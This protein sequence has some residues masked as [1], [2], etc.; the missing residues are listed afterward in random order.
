MTP[1]GDTSLLLGYAVHAIGA[2]MVGETV[3]V[4]QTVLFL[5]ELLFEHLGL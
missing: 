4:G 1:W 2:V 5:S 3:R